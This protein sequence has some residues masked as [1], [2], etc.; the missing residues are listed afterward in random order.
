MER[1]TSSSALDNAKLRMMVEADEFYIKAGLKGRS[2]NK[3]IMNSGRLPRHVGFKPRKD[4]GTFDKDHSM[5]TCIHQW[6]NRIT[7]FDISVKQPLIDMVCS[8]VCYD[9]TLYTDEFAT[10]NELNRHGFRHEHV[11][12]Y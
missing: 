5:I 10:Y 4:R 9:S 12:H 6:N 2:Y 8:N 7:H 3:D 11:N 1:L